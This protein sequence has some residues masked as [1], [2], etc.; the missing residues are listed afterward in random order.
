MD[1]KTVIVEFDDNVRIKVIG[2][3][4]QK[5]LDL[6]EVI[7]LFYLAIAKY[8]K[9][10][11]ENTEPEPVNDKVRRTYQVDRKVYEAANVVLESNSISNQR[12]VKSLLQEIVEKQ[13]L[14]FDI[15]ALKYVK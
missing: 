3:L 1:T 4:S 12:A 9:I 15:K 5:G 7:R 13:D 11:L 2:I 6:P 14:P 10:P 8:K